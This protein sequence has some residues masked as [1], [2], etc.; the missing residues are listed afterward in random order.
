MV[1]HCGAHIFRDLTGCAK[2]FEILT[3]SEGTLS[4][5]VSGRWNVFVTFL[6]WVIANATGL[7]RETWKAL[8]GTE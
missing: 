5:V 4:D 8:S 3:R 7:E 1:Y 6:L 2:G